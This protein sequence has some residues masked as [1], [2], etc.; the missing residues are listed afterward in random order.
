MRCTVL[1]LR[2]TPGM[3]PRNGFV[4]LR[5][6]EVDRGLVTDRRR[7]QVLRRHGVQADVDRL[8]PALAADVAELDQPR[9]GQLT[10][11]G[12][13]PPGV[14][15]VLH[16]ADLREAI[17]VPSEER[18]DAERRPGWIEHAVRERIR[19]VRDERQARVVGRH[20]LRRLRVAGLA[21]AV[22][23]EGDRVDADAGAEDRLV[24]HPVGPAD[25]R[26]PVVL[27]RV[28]ERS[29]VAGGELVAAQHLEV[30][31]RGTSGIG[32]AA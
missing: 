7:R 4:T 32:V 28:P 8:I 10:L 29:L 24:V 12:Q 23:H 25:A 11:E 9:A 6:Q 22:D 14:A 5:R 31:R 26:R 27:V 16:A 3:R 18:V 13:R 15:R 30:G 21:D 20:E 19:Q 17:Q 1:L 2:F